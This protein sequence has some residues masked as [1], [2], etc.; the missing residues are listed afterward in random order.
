MVQEVGRRCA[1]Q[2]IAT[3]DL[4]STII[5]SYKREALPTYQGGSGY[6]P[7]LA[8][9]AE[10]NLVLADEFRDGNV[11]AQKEPLRVA[12]RAFQALPPTVG[13]YYF[14]G[15][16]A[17]WE[18]Q[19]LSWL[20]DEQRADGPKGPITFGI[21]VRMTPNLKKHIVRLE[22]N[23]WKPYRED[24]GMLSGCA[25][26]LNYWPEDEERPEGAGPL[27]YI[28]IR[29]R[30][31]QGELFA[32]GSE[33]KYFVVLTTWGR[34]EILDLAVPTSGPPIARLDLACVAKASPEWAA[35]CAAIVPKGVMECATQQCILGPANDVCKQVSASPTEAQL[36]A[37]SVVHPD[38][39][40]EYPKTKVHFLF[41]AADC[42]EPVPIGLMYAT[43][44]TSE[45]EIGFVP[46]TPHPIASTAEGREAV[47]KAIDEGTK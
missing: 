5:E 23:L 19:L 6:Q 13:E 45:K 18:K 26:L 11:P 30:K 2:K 1:E 17:C 44:V 42:G 33:A 40:L 14:R 36:L 7:M 10:M 21:S 22:E 28:A 15:D 25:D 34:G 12:R 35:Q 39:V 46:K 31:R 32:D 37:D 4:D 8:L 24:A 3:V 9:W 29:M 20:R 38:A 27:R 43:K 16:S 41:G 47:R